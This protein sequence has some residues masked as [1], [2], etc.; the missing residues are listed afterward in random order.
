MSQSGHN[1]AATIDSFSSRFQSMTAIIAIDQ[2]S[3]PVDT[4]PDTQRGGSTSG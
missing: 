4:D 1:R 3:R 2:Q